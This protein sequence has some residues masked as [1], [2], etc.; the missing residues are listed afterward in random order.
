MPTPE[1][2]EAGT[3]GSVKILTVKKGKSMAQDEYNPVTVAER[4]TVATNASN[5]RVEADR[6]SPAD[7]IIAM[8]MLRGKSQLGAGLIRLFG[9]YRAT[10]LHDETDALLL[11]NSLKSLKNVMPAVV[12]QAQ[13][14]GVGRPETVARYVV[15]RWLDRTCKICTGT[16]KKKIEN[17]PANSNVN[18]NAC[19]GTGETKL[20]YGQA[21]ER[22][23]QYLL[24]SKSAAESRIRRRLKANHG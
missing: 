2:T 22:L 21:G 23:F 3:L 15:A 9:E 24:D 7:T 18:C 20:E 1:L 5:L 8:G 10:K 11:I 6:S 17:T 12:E 14:W 13:I 16:K 4:V 19:K